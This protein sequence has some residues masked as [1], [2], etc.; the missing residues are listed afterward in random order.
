[1]VVGLVISTTMY[2]EAEDARRITEQHRQIA[3]TERD[4]AR[5]A[6]AEGKK[7]KKDG[8]KIPAEGAKAKDKIA[9]EKPDDKQKKPD[10]KAKPDEN[11]KKPVDKD[12]LKGD[13]P[14]TKPEEKGMQFIEVDRKLFMETLKDIPSQ[15]ESTWVPGLYKSIQE[16]L[17]KLK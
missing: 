4:K 3:E 17:A 12:L 13:F 16:E 7:D 10:E 1:M 15:C 14:K 9:A 6:D 5:K 11:D 2:L 8:D